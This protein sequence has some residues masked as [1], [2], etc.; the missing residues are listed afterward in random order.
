MD[1]DLESKS[2]FKIYLMH[3][4]QHKIIRNGIRLFIVLVLFQLCRFFFIAFNSWMYI[5]TNVSQQIYIHLLGLKY[6]MYAILL[7]NAPFLIWSLFLKPRQVRAKKWANRLFVFSNLALL[8]FSIIDIFYFPFSFER[9]SIHFF[10]YLTT[11]K[12]LSILLIRFLYD[13][14]YAPLAFFLIIFGFIKANALIDKIHFKPSK[15]AGLLIIFT[16][17]LIVF[18]SFSSFQ[19]FS[20]L[21]KSDASQFV[22]NPF[23][24]AAILNTPYQILQSAFQTGNNRKEVLVQQAPL[25]VDSTQ[26]FEK[27]N[28]V[29]FILESFTSEASLLLHP[30]LKGESGIG[31]MP[32]LDSLMQQSY[33]FTNAYANGRRSIDAVPAILASFPALLKDENEPTLGLPEILKKEGYTTQFFHGAHNGSMAFDDLCKK[34]SIDE[35]YGMNE[36]NNPND[37]DETWGIWDEEFL[38]FMLSK[39]NQSPE[40]FFSTFFNLSSHNPFV[41][42]E[43]YAR[44]FPEGGDP[45]CKCIAYSDFAISQYFVKARNTH[46]YKNTLFVFTADHAAIPWHPDYYTPQKAFSIPLF[47]FDPSGQLKHKSNKV[48]QQID[49]MPGILTYLNY[50][51]NIPTYG[52]NFF[53]S[54]KADTVYTV[55]NQIPQLI[56]SKNQ[57]NITGS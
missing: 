36:Y 54:S 34:L 6:D 51:E 3:Y 43:K 28:I 39:Q 35:Y 32:F 50:Q 5:D 17:V 24:E 49:I 37:F 1:S 10:E 52:R 27:K 40:P 2:V 21:K 31:Y 38:Q 46:W 53:D 4:L 48:V 13:Y 29:I 11:Q 12:N 23:E 41:V 26:I 45:I 7:V 19:S 56:Y 9:L 15:K 16:P 30:E 22:Q 44:K 33:Y 42:P 20:L 55:I 8:I 57:M 25:V 47:V 18:W 14:W